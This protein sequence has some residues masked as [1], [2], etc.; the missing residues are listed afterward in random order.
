MIIKYI[1]FILQYKVSTT[2]MN[3]VVVFALLVFMLVRLCFCVAAGF[4]WIKIY[5]SGGFCSLK[6]GRSRLTISQGAARHVGRMVTCVHQ[7]MYC[8]RGR[9]LYTLAPA[10]HR[11]R[12]P[13]S[14]PIIIHRRNFRG[15]RTPIPPL[16]S[17]TKVAICPT[18]RDLCSKWRKAIFT[19]S[20]TWFHSLLYH[21]CVLHRK[22]L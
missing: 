14:R 19:T 18:R 4:R 15:T 22:V 7:S 6:W 16:I 11:D 2:V 5:I 10:P 8:T 1:M 21:D 20:N 9:V 17:A 13:I 3:L 12:Y